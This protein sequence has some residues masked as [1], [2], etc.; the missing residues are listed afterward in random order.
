MLVLLGT[1]CLLSM[2][3]VSE[4]NCN[5]WHEKE[6]GKGKESRV[7]YKAQE[8]FGERWKDKGLISAKGRLML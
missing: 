5:E 7:E 2:G 4:N 1:Y 8:V 3:I 6:K